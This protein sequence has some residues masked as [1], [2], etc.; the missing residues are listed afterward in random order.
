MQHAQGSLN[1][2]G[3]MHGCQSAFAHYTH[4]PMSC[5]LMLQSDLSISICRL[6]LGTAAHVMTLNGVRFFFPFHFYECASSL[7]SSNLASSVQHNSKVGQHSD[8][9]SFQHCSSGR[10]G[11]GGARG[12]TRSA[13]G[14][15]WLSMNSGV[16]TP[17]CTAAACSAA[18]KAADSGS[19]GNLS[20]S[21]KLSAIMRRH[22]RFLDPPPTTLISWA[23]TPYPSIFF[24]P[25]R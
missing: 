25:A 2:Q 14:G 10:G 19:V 6:L 11:E 22:S 7:N 1:S 8:T 4:H 9:C 18:P 13:K 24:N 17:A 20:G 21:W 16:A 12:L 5:T 15:E 23:F 3:R